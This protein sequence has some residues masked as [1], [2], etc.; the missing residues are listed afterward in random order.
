M[1]TSISL[2]FSKVEDPRI[3]RKKEYPLD[4]I[5]LV[6]LCSILA[7]GDGFSDMQLFGNEKLEFFR[8]NTSFQERHSLG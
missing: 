4:E 2:F 5:L 6:V 3:E 1:Q 8:K 7:G